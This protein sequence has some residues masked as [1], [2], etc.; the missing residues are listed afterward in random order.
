MMI[1]RMMRRARHVF[2]LPDVLKGIL[3][4]DVGYSSPTTVTLAYLEC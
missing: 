3:S 2:P 4:L 1:I